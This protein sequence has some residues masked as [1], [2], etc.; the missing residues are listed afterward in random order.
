M[1]H[2][3][4][5]KTVNVS[6]V[7]TIWMLAIASTTLLF[8]ACSS[9]NEASEESSTIG[10]AITSTRYE[11]E[12][13]TTNL[14]TETKWPGYSGASYLANWSSNGQYATFNVTT[15]TAGAYTLSFRYSSGNG[16]ATRQ[17]AIN[18]TVVENN[19]TFAATSNWS[20]WTTL[21][22]VA[23]LNAG[24]NKITLTFVSGA[25]SANY[26]N[27]DY[28][29]VTG[30]GDTG[31]GDAG[32]GDGGGSKGS[33]GTVFPPRNPNPS[34]PSRAVATNDFLSSLGISGGTTDM[35]AE[36]LKYLGVRLCR[37][38]S[39]EGGVT[40]DQ[41]V[42]IAQA[43]N[44]KVIW[45]IKSGFNDTKGDSIQKE[46]TNVTKVAQAGYLLGIEGPNE[47]DIFTLTYQGATNANGAS[48]EP[49]AKLQRDLYAA[50]KAN[51]VLGKY[52][53]FHLTHNGGESN[54]VGLQ[55]LKIPSGAGALL[56]DGTTYADYANVHNYAIWKD[57]KAP[58]DN[59]AWRAASSTDNQT[60]GQQEWLYSD[61]IRAWL[62]GYPGY[63]PAQAAALPKITTETGW[64][65]GSGGN[66][67]QAKTIL[68]IYLSQFL[69]GWSATNVYEII[70]RWDEQFGFYDVNGNV[71][72]AAKYLHNLTSLLA[73]DEELASPGT[74]N[75]SIASSPATV[76]AF[77]TQKGDGKGN[78]GHFFLVVWDERW[79]AKND[80]IV[81]SLGKSYS[82]AKVWDV[83]A[84]DNTQTP[85]ASQNVS[86]VALAMT[87]HPKIV[88]I[89]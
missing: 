58:D 5:F 85:Q 28:L 41:V 39:T 79:P 38:G 51:S 76:H 19:K 37:C 46:I 53:V 56:P 59:I 66:D 82:N 18:G 16:A 65:A 73:D 15:A 8:P 17:L 13:A 48:W 50:V 22:V 26:I 20:T 1:H 14:P 6:L 86:S 35:T 40:G 60:S 62:K 68:N 55:W 25:G 3:S 44:V 64:W 81:V 77:L 23:Q 80:N 47:P 88:E 9:G 89:W 71:R 32:T 24:A 74:L 78:N 21:S 75:W 67:A 7:P 72:P 45:G 29:D 63:T 42:R 2:R 52:P 12:S 11:A 43:G 4:H 49:V 84:G 61:Y 10:A 36:R 69:R 31:G 57:S 27:L 30:G 54:N 83:V 87:D 34:N 33:I 70:D